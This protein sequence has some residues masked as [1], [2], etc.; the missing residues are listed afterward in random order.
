MFEWAECD[1]YLY[2]YTHTKSQGDLSFVGFFSRS[3]MSREKH[4]RLWCGGDCTNLVKYMEGIYMINCNL[5]NYNQENILQ[6]L[7]IYYY[8][9]LILSEMK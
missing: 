7:N 9:D 3:H 8:I 5:N 4:S 1:L 6:K 2:A